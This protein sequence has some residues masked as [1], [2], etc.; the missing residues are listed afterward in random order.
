[1]DPI[2]RDLLN[3]AINNPQNIRFEDACKLACQ[4]GW[5]L[6]RIKGS[7]HIFHH[8]KAP[9]IREQYPQPLNLQRRDDGKAK[10]YQIRQMLEMAK[11]MGII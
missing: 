9:L 7:H 8:P 3:S 4:M 5:N 1:M 6:E 10:T 2:D 11:E